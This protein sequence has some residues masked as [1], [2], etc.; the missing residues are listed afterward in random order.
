MAELADDL[1]PKLGRPGLPGGRVNSWLAISRNPDSP[2]PPKRQATSTSITE[3]QARGM[4]VWAEVHGISRSQAHRD[5]LDLA[6]SQDPEVW[7]RMVSAE[8]AKVQA[9]QTAA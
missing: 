8:V 6:I 5:M 9:E 3:F 7:E 1:K 4:D 2:R